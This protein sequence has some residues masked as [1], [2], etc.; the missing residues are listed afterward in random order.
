MGTGFVRVPCALRIPPELTPVG[1]L[2]VPVPVPMAVLVPVAA[3][4]AIMT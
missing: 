1:G 2:A 3:M 4:R